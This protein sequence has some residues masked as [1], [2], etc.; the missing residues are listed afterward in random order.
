M[1]IDIR[2]A[3]DRYLTEYGTAGL[4]KRNFERLIDEYHKDSQ[5]LKSLSNIKKIKSKNIELKQDIS[6]LIDFE[7]FV[8]KNREFAYD[9]G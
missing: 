6:R 2:S 3:K 9:R 7:K 5:D 1:P 4:F 8:H